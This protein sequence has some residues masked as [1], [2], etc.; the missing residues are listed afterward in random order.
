MYKVVVGIDQLPFVG[1][2]D[3]EAFMQMGLVGVK[4]KLW[5]GVGGIGLTKMGTLRGTKFNELGR[6]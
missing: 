2:Q 4:L 5:V 3:T 1:F 6:F